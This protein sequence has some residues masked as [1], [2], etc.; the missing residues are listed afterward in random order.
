[1]VRLQDGRVLI[2]GGFKELA[3]T[4]LPDAGQLEKIQDETLKAELQAKGHVFASDTDTEAVVHLITDQMKAGHGPVEAVRRS[5]GVVVG[6]GAGYVLLRHGLVTD[7]QRWIDRIGPIRGT[8]AFGR[9]LIGFGLGILARRLHDVAQQS[10]ARRWL[11]NP[12]WFGASVWWAWLLLDAHRDLGYDVI[13]FAGPVF[14]VLVLQAAAVDISPSSRTGRAMLRAGVWSFGVYAFHRVFMDAFN[15]LTAEPLH[16]WS[17][18]VYMAPNQV[19]LHYLVLKVTVV[20]IVS[21]GAAAATARWIERL[22]IR[23]PSAAQ[24]IRHLSGGNQQKAIIGRWLSEEVRVF[25]FDE[26]TRG[27]DVGAKSEIYALLQRL[28]A[29]G[30]A[31]IVVSS[32]L[33]E[34]LGVADRVAIMRGGALVDVLD[35][36]EATEESVLKKALPP[37]ISTTA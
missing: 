31:V 21:V 36:S 33:P 18:P 29:D 15:Y 16:W 11:Q 2:A 23:T 17:T 19:W 4:Y 20:T 22:S 9:A 34:V 25:L 8:E 12:V 35:R 7:A 10:S 37:D 13:Y 6:I 26:P 24:L 1:M 28:A 30:A 32:E 27:I 14:A 3:K 5:L